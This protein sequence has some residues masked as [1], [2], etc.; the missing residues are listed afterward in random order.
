MPHR[1][2][3]L[4]L[5]GCFASNI[6][7]AIDLFDVTNRLAARQEPDNPPI[8]TWQVLSPDGQPVKSS[9][10]Y[11]ITVDGSLYEA[12]TANTIMIPAFGSPRPQ[13]L[14]AV[15]MRQSCLITWLQAQ[16]QAGVAIAATCSGSFL[17]AESGLL[18]GR[19]ATTSWWLADDFAKRYKQVNLDIASML[20]DDQGLMCSGA[21]M[22][23][24]DLS[25][26]LIE[27]IAGRDIAHQCARYT[28]LDEQRRSQAPYIILNHLR[29]HDPL[30]TKAEKWIQENLDQ[31]IR[32]ED[33][34]AHVAASPRTLIRHFK[35]ATGDT[36]QGFVRKLRIET[37]KALLE[38]T[39]LRLSEILARL[40]YQDESTFRRTFKKYTALSPSDYRRRFGVKQ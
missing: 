39:Q 12:P 5:E 17:L 16:H 37:G 35:E 11:F 29:T 33:I 22:S 24:L 40:G 1:V 14:I 20:T 25:L 3:L 34:A 38:N 9:N 30:I 31:D 18:N 27:K 6:L 28:V 7:G 26:Y 2:T 19:P 32:I 13:E 15:L 23:H 21:G 36:P 10:G 8:F 4:A